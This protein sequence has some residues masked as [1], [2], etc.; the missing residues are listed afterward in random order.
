MTPLHSEYRAIRG[1]SRI[2]EEQPSEE[3][4][5]VT[6]AVPYKQA[7]ATPASESVTV[8]DIALEPTKVDAEVNTVVPD[9]TRP[10]EPAVTCPKKPNGNYETE[11]S[12][13]QSEEIS[14]AVVVEEP[15][16]V[17]A[18]INAVVPD[19]TSS[20]GP[21]FTCPRGVNGEIQTDG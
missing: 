14:A 20:S 9:A 17:A 13:I 6:L 16:K 12:C 11:S 4:T 7:N 1:P 18:E 10:A 19:S 15:T 3:E 8:L 5:I 21:E 2:E